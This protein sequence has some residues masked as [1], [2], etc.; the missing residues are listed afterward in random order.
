MV[1]V[2]DTVAIMESMKME[3]SITSEVSG[4]VSKVNVTV[5]AFIEMDNDILGVD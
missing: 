5:G 1:S 3:Q 4:T 2:G